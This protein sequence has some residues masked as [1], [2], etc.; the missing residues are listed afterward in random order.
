MRFRIGRIPTGKEIPRKRYLTHAEA[1]ALFQ[2]EVVVEEKLDGKQVTKA[3][4]TETGEA[5]ILCG[6]S[7]RDVHSIQYDNLPGLYIVWDVY[8][9]GTKAFVGY[10]AKVALARKYNFPIPPLLFRGVTTHSDVLKML[11]RKSSFGA[12]IQEGVVVKSVDSLRRGKI[13][14]HEFVAGVELQGHW[15]RRKGL[16]KKN[17]VVHG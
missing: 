12:E 2:S 5:L 1:D 13:V 8:D 11:D 15:T 17:R 9:P 16:V 10:D 6:E 4:T 3:F 7:M 14:R